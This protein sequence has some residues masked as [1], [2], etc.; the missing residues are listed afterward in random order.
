M[1]TLEKI[2]TRSPLW[3]QNIGIAAFGVMWKHRRFGGK[4]KE[5]VD[6]F[7]EHE[8]FTREE[9]LSY[10]TNKLRELVRVCYYE[11][12]YYHRLF[13]D[14][15]IDE[16]AVS[17]FSLDD[18]RKLPLLEKNAIRENPESFIAESAAKKKL[19]K[20]HTSGSTGTPLIVRESSLTH[21]IISA[22]YEARCR[23]WAGVNHTMSRA[24][25]G[26]RLV[27]PKP[28][29]GPPYWRY[30]PA[31]RQVYFSAFHI[32]PQN[33]RHYVS[34]LNYYNAD[35]LVG[36]ASSHYF[37]ARMIEEQNLTVYS[38]KCVLTS[39]EK[40]TDD[41][42]HTLER[43]YRCEVF[44]G[45]SGVECCCLAS[46]CE[47]HRLHISPDV[48]II[49]LVDDFGNHV[50]SGEPGEIVAT[51]L[52]NYDQPLLRFRTGDIAIFGEGV[53]ACGREMP[54]LRE[55]VG[56]IEDTIYG[57]DGRQTVRFH[58]IFVGI[59]SIRE[60]QLIQE[61]LTNFTIRVVAPNGLN[62]T[63]CNEIYRRIH[64]RL[65]DV[66]VRIECVNAIERT[67]RGKFKAIICRLTADEKRRLRREQL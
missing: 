50:N 17:N 58:G 52:L 42:R 63:E 22:A 46:E 35:Y 65:G 18:L 12:P 40:L 32:S 2:Y 44:D 39:S 59:P 57:V 10:Q 38:P 25:I 48:G 51:G 7:S 34:A 53:C 30:N 61:T 43:V 41:M 6:E 27:V 47:Y 9:W 20:Y 28:V 15:G 19:H 14:H 11:T 5:F 66:K 37:L 26:G 16:E 33:V 36:Y 60:G 67:A 24:M 31:E 29:S 54:V 56:R 3:I 55:L 62:D 64:D 13:K 23:K 8:R 49:E 45:Y 4:F 21:Q 1:G